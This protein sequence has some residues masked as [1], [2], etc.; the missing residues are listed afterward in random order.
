MTKYVKIFKVDSLHFKLL[1]DS[2][3]G[4]YFPGE[5]D[6]VFRNSWADIVDDIGVSGRG[7]FV[8]GDTDMVFVGREFPK[9]DV[10]W[11]DVISNRLVGV[12]GE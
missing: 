10:T 1:F 7:E 2:E 9:D 8:A 5:E 4:D 11:L 3:V 6:V 12:D